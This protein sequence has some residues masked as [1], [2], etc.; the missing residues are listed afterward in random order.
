[1][2]RDLS[3]SLLVPTERMV[4]IGDTTHDVAMAHAAGAAA[5]YY[6]GNGGRT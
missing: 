2:L 4:M 5:V 3:E 6:I 1:M